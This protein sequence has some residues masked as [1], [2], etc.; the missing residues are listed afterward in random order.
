MADMKKNA[1]KMIA[2]GMAIYFIFFM[3]LGTRTFAQHVIRIATTPEAR[4]LAYEMFSTGREASRALTS[5][6]RGMISGFS[7]RSTGY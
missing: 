5:R 1:P 2:G 6:A 3:S 4:E 7:H